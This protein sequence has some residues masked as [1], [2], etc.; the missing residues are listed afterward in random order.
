MNWEK[1]HMR[2]FINKNIFAKIKKITSHYL[3]CDVVCMLLILSA[4]NF[5]SLQL[6]RYIPEPDRWDELSY[7]IRAF[8]YNF[9][10]S[11]FD[12]QSSPLFVLWFKVISFFID[13]RLHL[14]YVHLRLISSI[15]PLALYL[16]CRSFKLSEFPSVVVGFVF[17]SFPLLT[18]ASRQVTH[19][20]ALIFLF[21]GALAFSRKTTLGKLALFDFSLFIVTLIRPE[22][23][24]SLLIINVFLFG[25]I[26]SK[27]IKKDNLGSVPL[28]LSFLPLLF[29]IFYFSQAPSNNFKKSIY[30][31][32]DYSAI[33]YGEQG[34]QGRKEDL[35]ERFYGK[36]DLHSDSL[37]EILFR[38]PKDVLEHI[39]FS[40]KNFFKYLL[41]TLTSFRY[42]TESVNGLMLILLVVLSF[43]FLKNQ[44]KSTASG[45]EL[46]CASASVF[47]PIIISGLLFGINTRYFVPLIA[48]LLSIVAWI[49]NLSQFPKYNSIVLGVLFNL[50]TILTIPDFNL[51]TYLKPLYG[52][53][54]GCC[55]EVTGTNDVASAFKMFKFKS[56][57][58]TLSRNNTLLL[59]KNVRNLDPLFIKSLWLDEDNQKLSVADY[60][61]RHKFDLMRLDDDLLW[62]LDGFK[63]EDSNFIQ[64]L[65]RIISTGNDSWL[66]VV[67]VR[68]FNTFLIFPK[69]HFLA[70]NIL[71]AFTEI[72]CKDKKSK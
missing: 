52:P 49:I 15:L 16:Y 27:V 41:I 4:S 57:L 34:I 68:C 30:V 32:R 14:Y 23:L 54:N 43:F 11:F 36:I 13:D 28:F 63:A 65:K 29:Q 33:R 17:C 56:S 7:L 35:F 2:L 1:D 20:S 46:L 6:Y 10:D 26:A 72:Q 24:V 5:W 25:F 58:I 60:F 71:D 48:I 21:M 45:F 50:V 44:F 53:D 66:H 40:T 67:Q 64:D 3:F 38:N 12:Y 61:K 31:Y 47:L 22:F 62:W 37:I 19:L 18:V 69:S 51:Y 8:D 42:L 59:V 55:T 9:L 39:K 70:Q